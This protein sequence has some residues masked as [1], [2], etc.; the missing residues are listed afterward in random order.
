MA[1]PYPRIARH[2]ALRESAALADALADANAPVTAAAA[3]IRYHHLTHLVLS[4][5]DEAG[6]RPRV[7]P[8]LV[9]A[10][11]AVQPVQTLSVDA[12][13]RGFEDVRDTLDAAGVRVMLLK[14]LYFAERLYG[15]YARR[16]Q[17]DLDI[18]VHAH[19]RR[20]AARALVRA[21]F[22]RRAYDLHS[23]TFVRDQLKIDVHGW[24]RRAPAY[25]IDEAAVWTSARTVRVGGLDVVTLSDE[26]TLTLLGLASFEDLGQGMVRL[27]QLLDMFLLVRQVDATFD[28]RGFFDRRAAE[29]VDGVLATVLAL[30]LSV[31]E[32]EQD[33]SQLAAALDARSHLVTASSRGEVLDLVFA[34]RKH[35]ANLAWFGRVYPG[36]LARYLAAFWIAGFP[37]NLRQLHAARLRALLRAAVA[38]ACAAP[39][40]GAL[41]SSVS[42]CWRYTVCAKRGDRVQVT[43]PRAAARRTILQSRYVTVEVGCP[44]GDDIAWLEDFLG[45]AFRPCQAPV[46]VHYSVDATIDE[47]L[48]DTYARC[49]A[50]GHSTRCRGVRP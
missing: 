21:G 42:V 33:A 1:T 36:S 11:E 48:F 34:P 8:A 13:L 12:L 31:F 16:P 32:G 9:S 50:T 28:W 38:C 3:V 30:V 49:Q 35:P 4:T 14:G 5:I 45:P 17:F 24:L 20:A 15:G 7:S 22:T 43:H 47:Q 6:L 41:A 19:D 46:D 26:Y 25:R 44:S 2:A 18:L 37:A 23:Q 40:P 27:K 10:I 29:G 39:R